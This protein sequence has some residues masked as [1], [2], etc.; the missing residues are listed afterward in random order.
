MSDIVERLCH[1]GR[2]RGDECLRIEAAAEIKR[3]RGMERVRA[4][5]AE[6]RRLNAK[7]DA[8][9]KENQ[10]LT[11]WAG[12]ETIRRALNPQNTDIPKE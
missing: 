12:L 4:L 9:L 8:A 11:S 10:R 7:L 1:N 5:E 3:L 6:I 2:V